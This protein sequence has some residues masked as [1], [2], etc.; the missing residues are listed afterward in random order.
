MTDE[1]IVDSDL[2]R[3]RDRHI[4]GLC[5]TDAVEKCLSF[6]QCP[7][8]SPSVAT[9]GRRLSASGDASTR[10]ATRV[11]QRFPT[12]NV[13]IS[14]SLSMRCQAVYDRRNKRANR[15][16]W[17]PKQWF[18]LISV[19]ALVSASEG[20]LNTSQ[21]RAQAEREVT[22]TEAA[23]TE[24]AP[25]ETAQPAKPSPVKKETES[26]ADEEARALSQ[27]G[28]TA[29]RSGRYESALTYFEQSYALSQ[30][31]ALLFNIGSCAERLRRDQRAIEAYEA[32]LRAR[33]NADNREAV[34]ARIEILRH[35]VANRQAKN[36]VAPVTSPPPPPTPSSTGDDANP[37]S[38]RKTTGFA[39][40]G[41]AGGA[42]AL[43]ASAIPW[44]LD[45]RDATEMC[46]LPDRVCDN[47][48]KL[49][50]RRN[51]AL[52]TWIGGSA[53]AVGSAVA[54]LFLLL[55]KNKKHTATE[56]RWRC[57]PGALSLSC[58][59]LL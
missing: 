14:R 35:H 2:D 46:G 50:T 4:A 32:Y 17:M 54:G 19:V 36:D 37:S 15:D 44:W 18:V 57:A 52:G 12:A 41:V 33:P 21:V 53:I 26:S 8:D 20:S 49:E 10:A 34:E 59:G 22:Q 45:R 48:N 56:A 28:L 39:L 7:Q 9:V 13:R 16:L 30:R 40:L 1:L 58:Q 29:Y 6:R 27:A 24:T 43:A 31:A 42:L 5:K 47:Q 51:A 25:T 55:R 23:P 3:R 38:R 11:F